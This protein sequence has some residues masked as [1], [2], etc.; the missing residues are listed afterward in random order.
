MK[1]RLNGVDYP[2]APAQ[3]IS[4]LAL[5]RAKIEHE[6]QALDASYRMMAKAGARGAI[7][8]IEH[9]VAAQSSQAEAKRVRPPKGADPVPH[10]F[11]LG[12]VLLQDM[13]QHVTI[14]IETSQTDLD[15]APTITACSVKI[16]NPGE[17][18][19]PLDPD[20]NIRVREDDGLKVSR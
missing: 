1:L 7:T 15:G 2:L 14:V 19:R 18:G 16:T 5:F 3:Q 10:L 6:Y 4:I 11:T 20:G 9:R 12:E 17:T 8:W 13:M